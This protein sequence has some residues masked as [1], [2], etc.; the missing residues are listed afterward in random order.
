MKTAV[1]TTRILRMTESAW[2]HA[3]REWGETLMNRV[4]A[5][6]L[7]SLCGIS[8]GALSPIYLSGHGTS[9]SVALGLLAGVIG[10]GIGATAVLAALWLRAPVRQR[11]DERAE[12]AHREASDQ[13]ED[14]RKH[15]MRND[16]LFKNETVYVCDLVEPGAARTELENRSFV[17]CTILG[18]AV[19]IPRLDVE[20]IDS[21]FDG[22]GY[23]APAIYSE[24]W[25]PG[26]VE[27]F[28]C[29]FV[30]CSF[31][32]VGFLVV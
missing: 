8:A 19:L 6:L 7:V 16:Q 12:R 5:W 4:W 10:L 18:P 32:G 14:E 27:L 23:P 29:S 21:R 2:A 1:T 31:V 26:T 25:I 30:R 15:H 20:F 11:N 24:Y 22:G 13:T 28:H 3:L 17:D 9:A